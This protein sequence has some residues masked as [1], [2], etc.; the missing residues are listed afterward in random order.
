MP[1]SGENDA[2]PDSRSADS[3]GD[4]KALSREECVGIARSYRSERD[5]ATLSLRSRQDLP[6]GAGADGRIAM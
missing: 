4:R 3:S 5:G 1:L 2:Q 6:D